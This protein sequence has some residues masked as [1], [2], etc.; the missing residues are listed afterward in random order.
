VIKPALVAAAAAAVALTACEKKVE[1]PTDPGV[2]Y[3]VLFQKDGSVKFNKIA[4]KQPSIEYCAARLEELRMR[5]LRLGGTRHEIT[6]AYQGR[7]LWVN[8][9]GVSISTRLDGG[10]FQA[11]TRTADGRLAIP[12]YVARENGVPIQ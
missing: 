7:F 2:C 3:Q 10:R 4:D 6:G 11:L 8:P 12:G 1:A 9:G 5:F